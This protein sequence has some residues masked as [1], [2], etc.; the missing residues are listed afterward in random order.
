M[1]NES[2]EKLEVDGT[3]IAYRRLGNGRP[4]LVLNGFAATS[5]DWDHGL[6][7]SSELILLDNR[8]IGDCT[9]DERRFDI[10]RLA[11]DAAHV[12]ETLGFER[13]S[14]LGWSM[15]GFISQTLA[16]QQPNRV[17]KLIL[18]STDFGGSEADLASAAVWSQ[19]VDTSGTLHDQA[20]PLL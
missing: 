2:F 1:A 4:L 8:G 19:L 16:L 20:K 17:N 9:D 14:M 6:A 5:S 11:N 10:A 7:S 18:L 3:Q 13:I 15:G 12:I